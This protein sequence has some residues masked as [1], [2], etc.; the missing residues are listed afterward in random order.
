[1]QTRYEGPWDVPPMQTSYQGPFWTNYSGLYVTGPTSADWCGYFIEIWNGRVYTRWRAALWR[2][3]GYEGAT[4][5]LLPIGG[6]RRNE[7][8][9]SD[10]LPVTDGNKCPA[11]GGKSGLVASNLATDSKNGRRR[12]SAWRPNARDDSQEWLDMEK[13]AALLQKCVCRSL[14]AS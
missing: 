8:G 4:T 2:L 5:T 13:A 10:N 14:A 6:A 9:C 11:I 1:M 12:P 7:S 3:E